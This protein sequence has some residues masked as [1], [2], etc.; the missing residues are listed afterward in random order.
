MR[1]LMLMCLMLGMVSCR[2]KPS[3]TIVLV[4]PDGFRG[5]AILRWKQP[6]GIKL[7]PGEL[8]YTLTIPA[9]GVLPIQGKNLMVDWHIQQARYASGQ[10]LA[11]GDQHTKDEEGVY[12]WDMGLNADAKESWYVVGRIK[13]L[14]GVLERKMGVA[15]IPN[16]PRGKDKPLP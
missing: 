15:P 13:D 2:E 1:Y 9:S 7:T 12:L 8:N 14:D 3:P 10:P 5:V 6:D 16:P 4:F 11:K